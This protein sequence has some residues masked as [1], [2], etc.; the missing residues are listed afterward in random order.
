MDYEW[1][2]SSLSLGELAGFFDRYWL[3]GIEGHDPDAV[4][5]YRNRFKCANRCKAERLVFRILL[6]LSFQRSAVIPLHKALRPMR[7]LGPY[8]WTVS[9]TLVECC[10]GPEV[11]AIVMV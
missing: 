4:K 10:R 2:F 8:Y 5:K 11:P 6:S 1:F 9:M 7:E 3:C